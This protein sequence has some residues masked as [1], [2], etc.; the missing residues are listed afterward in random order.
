METSKKKIDILEHII[1]AVAG[2]YYNINLTRNLVPGQMYQA[3]D[4]KRR[5]ACNTYILDTNDPAKTDAGRTSY[6]DV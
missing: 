3:V 1:A 5:D 4:G 6:C 2:A